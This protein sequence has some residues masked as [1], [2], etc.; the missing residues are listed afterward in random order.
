MAD[1][2][3]G[4]GVTVGLLTASWGTYY[5]YH[6]DYDVILL[7][8]LGR[9]WAMIL[10]PG[11]DDLHQLYHTLQF[12]PGLNVTN[13]KPCAVCAREIKEIDVS[14]KPA[15]C[16]AYEQAD[17]T[18]VD[19]I[20]LQVLKGQC[21]RDK[22]AIL[23]G[24][25]IRYAIDAATC[26]AVAG[27][28]GFPETMRLKP[29]DYIT[30]RLYTN[31]QVGRSTVN[32]ALF[33][34][35]TPY[36]GAY[37]ISAKSTVLF[38]HWYLVDEDSIMKNR[39][40]QP[41]LPPLLDASITWES[42][43]G[44]QYVALEHIPGANNDERRKNLEY[45]N[46]LGSVGYYNTSDENDFGAILTDRLHFNAWVRYKAADGSKYFSFEWCP[47]EKN[48]GKPR[49]VPFSKW[50]DSQCEQ[51]IQQFLTSSVLRPYS[52]PAGKSVSKR[53]FGRGGFAL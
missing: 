52:A 46:R 43:G 1:I 11:E 29:R 15:S 10:F 53:V 47:V 23:G 21:D 14:N 48:D 33:P 50:S 4:V 18:R 5:L 32:A 38:Q 3:I 17:I 37:P 27:M 34:V 45:I 25:T 20:A 13:R 39:R 30:K 31:G 16:V 6:N 36:Q 42:V 8:P 49:P 51:Y 2:G 9:L 22:A 44:N 12:R 40:N 35:G 7:T 28:Y 19:P 24:N 41:F 26:V